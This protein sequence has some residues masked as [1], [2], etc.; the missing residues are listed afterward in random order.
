M[1]PA[2][3][4][5]VVRAPAHPRTGEPLYYIVQDD[6]NPEL[7]TL[8]VSGILRGEETL[9]AVVIDAAYSDKI[10][11][12]I[13]CPGDEGETPL[14]DVRDPAQPMCHPEDL[15]TEDARIDGII[16]RFHATAPPVPLFSRRN[17]PWLIVLGVC[18]LFM[19]GKAVSC[20]YAWV[21][22][23]SPEYLMS[24]ENHVKIIEALEPLTEKVSQYLEAGDPS[25][26]AD[27]FRDLTEERNRLIEQHPAFVVSGVHEKNADLVKRM[28]SLNAKYEKF[29]VQLRAEKGK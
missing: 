20:S 29:E 25:A 12:A 11:M 13:S 1:D 22:R 21:T 10:G 15:E 17:A 23:K 4:F 24:E 2:K 9:H 18:C 28:K 8:H 3:R 19:F 16:A 5:D 26:A 7:L 6:D 14:M 27:A